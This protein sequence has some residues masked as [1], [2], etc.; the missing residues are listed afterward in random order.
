[1]NSKMKNRLYIL[2]AAGIAS[3]TLGVWWFWKAPAPNQAIIP[4]SPNPTMTTLNN[5]VASI[6]K[7]VPTTNPTS[8]DTFGVRGSTN[9]AGA[10]RAYEQG[11]IDKD[12]VRREMVKEK[13]KQSLDFF[14]KVIDQ[15]GQSVFGAKVKGDVELDPGTGYGKSETHYAETDAEGQFSFVGLH[16]LGLGI[17]PQKEGYSYDLRLPSKRPN[18][19][20][21]DPNNPVVFTMWR[22]RGAEP[23]IHIEL[24]SRV[25][26]DGTPAAFNLATGKKNEDRELRITLLRNPLQIQR[27]HDKYDWTAKIEMLNGGLLVENDLY[28]NWAPDNGYQPFFE[29][30]MSTNDVSWS[31]KLTQY[32]YFKNAQG[33][34]GRLFIGLSTDS[35]R[36]DTGISIQ[37]WINPSGSQNLE[38]DPAKQIR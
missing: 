25:P 18:D 26:Y 11:L 10:F 35:M 30:S 27:G 31:H 13:S 23:M 21:P 28:P 24:D 34:Y 8:P 2:L 33:Q 14:G 38:F 12:Q 20:Q 32:F 9:L 19:Y 15:Y 22:L 7:A 4:D 17:W 1:M 5:S 36:P 37:A 16:G 29:T 3:L 6:H